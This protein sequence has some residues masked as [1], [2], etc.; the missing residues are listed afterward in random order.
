MCDR[1][2]ARFETD[3]YGFPHPQL[4]RGRL[5]MRL[6]RKCGKLA[7]VAEWNLDEGVCAGCH[8][9]AARAVEATT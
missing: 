3:G 8:P 5:R 1:C 7:T 2:P 6:C 4:A 9:R